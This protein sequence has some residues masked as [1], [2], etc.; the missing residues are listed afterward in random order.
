MGEIRKVPLEWIVPDG[1]QIL[2]ANHMLVAEANGQMI[3]TFFQV[4]PPVVLEG[5]EGKWDTIKS[6]PAIAVARLAIPMQ[7][8][9]KMIEV[10][11]S[12]YAKELGSISK[13]EHEEDSE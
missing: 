8:M 6:V 4:Q 12:R 3:V 1:L 2:F 5:E 7:Q 10:L 11:G 9:G 13:A